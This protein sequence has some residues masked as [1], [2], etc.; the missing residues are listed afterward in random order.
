MA[1]TL[2]Q[3]D[4]DAIVAAI[5]TA[6]P[7]VKLGDGVTHG[8]ATA[9]LAIK[10]LAIN[11]PDGN[12]FTITA[13]GKGIVLNCED[14]AIAITALGYGI[15]FD[16]QSD[17]IHIV[18]PGNGISMEVAGDGLTIESEGD[19]ISLYPTAGGYGI[20]ADGVYGFDGILS[21]TTLASFFVIDTT[22]TYVDAVDGSVIKELVKAIFTID[23][24]TL[25]GE[26]ARS[27]LNAVRKL[28]N[29]WSISGTV[30][31]VFK[32]NDSTI[33][34]SQD[35]TATPGADPITGIDN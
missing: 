1:Q 16:V 15:V 30:L 14:D 18:S 6:K 31:S 11:N 2:T 22:K 10:S 35:L 23:L 19:A 17:G 24:S 3:E 13:A 33:A 7:A 32:E 29:K 20:L 9:T 12:A 27:L 25:S 4:L 26:A 5:N 21:P 34:Y 28:R 8:G